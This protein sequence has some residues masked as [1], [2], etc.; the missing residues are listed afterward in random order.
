MIGCTRI[1]R[2]PL[3]AKAAR[4]GRRGEGLACTHRLLSPVAV[5]VQAGLTTLRAGGVLFATSSVTGS[6]LRLGCGCVTESPTSDKSRQS[7]CGF[8]WFSREGEN[9]FSSLSCVVTPDCHFKISP[10]S[11]GTGSS[12]TSDMHAGMMAI[13]GRGCMM[14]GRAGGG[15]L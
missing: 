6:V 1:Q 11:S 4:Q 8:S 14:H 12:T 15:R 13:P 5:P 7:A 10:N 3:Q 9:E 2:A